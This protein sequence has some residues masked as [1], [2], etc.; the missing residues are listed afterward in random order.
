MLHAMF[1]RYFAGSIGL[2]IL[3][4][5][6]SEL[7]L[8]RS[9]AM[10]SKDDVSSFE[11]AVVLSTLAL[12][13]TVKWDDVTDHFSDHP[14]ALTDLDFTQEEL[15]QVSHVVRKVM[16]RAHSHKNNLKRVFSQAFAPT[17]TPGPGP[18]QK[19]MAWDMMWEALHTARHPQ[20]SMHESVLLPGPKSSEDKEPGAP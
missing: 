5:S 13:A 2:I 4:E 1:G 14:E 15:D 10:G 19:A 12:E 6:E 16:D 8:Q 3:G 17:P 7:G 18:A 20:P 11:N 9:Q